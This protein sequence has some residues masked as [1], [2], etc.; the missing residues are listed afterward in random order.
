MAYVLDLVTDESQWRMYLTLL[1]IGSLFV[2]LQGP[3]EADIEEGVYR[4]GV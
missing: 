2:S 1:L 3:A 4:A